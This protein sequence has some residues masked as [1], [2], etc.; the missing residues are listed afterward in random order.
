MSHDDA[1]ADA[2]CLLTGSASSATVHMYHFHK[3]IK[4]VKVSKKTVFPTAHE[5]EVAALTLTSKR[6][7]CS[8]QSR[9]WK[10]RGPAPGGSQLLEA[11]RCHVAGRAWCLG[12]AKP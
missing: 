10:S 11:W 4:I 1:A 9:H 8:G 3:H 12:P 7:V 6:S 5:H 2:M